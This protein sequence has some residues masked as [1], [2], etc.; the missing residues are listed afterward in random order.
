[1]PIP[2]TYLYITTNYMGY[3]SAIKQHGPIVHPAKVKREEAIA[4]MLAGAPIIVHDPATKMTYPLTMD[5]M[6]KTTKEATR[7]IPEP[8]TET[9]LKGAPKGAGDLGLSNPP[10]QVE[11]KTTHSLE[12][13]I[14]EQQAAKTEPISE[15]VVNDAN[16]EEGI[17]ENPTTKISI[18]EVIEN[19]KA[20]TMTESDV[21]W[22]DY[23]KA[24]RRQIRAI[25]TEVAAN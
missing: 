5:T 15:T 14:A 21:H 22:S 9:V 18:D 19:I 10:K 25:I 6:N 12:K 11:P 13:I 24:E 17:E 7:V 20:G 1:M 3:L 8:M 2:E 16:D 4:L 23:T